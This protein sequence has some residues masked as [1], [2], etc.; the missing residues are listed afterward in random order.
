MCSLCLKYHWTSTGVLKSVIKKKKKTKKQKE[1]DHYREQVFNLFPLEKWDSS[2]CPRRRLIEMLQSVSYNNSEIN[3][4]VHFLIPG[5]PLQGRCAVPTCAPLLG[6]AH[7]LCPL[8][9]PSSQTRLRAE[10]LVSEVV[11]T[12]NHSPCVIQRITANLKQRRAGVEQAQEHHTP[13]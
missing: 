4:K 13:E 11:P 10:G 8:L 5:L 9:Q 1:Q 3:N 2:P 12:P 6:W 7:I